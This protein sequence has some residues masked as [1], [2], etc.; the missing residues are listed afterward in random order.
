MDQKQDIRLYSYWRSSASWRIR[1]ALNLKKQSFKIE[2]INLLQGQQLSKEYSD[3]NPN[4]L[5]PALKVNDQILVQSPAI[6]EY[7]EEVYPDFKLLPTDP[8]ERA[9]VRGLMNVIVCDIHPVQN[10]RVLKKV[11]SLVNSDSVKQEWASHFIQLGFK[12]LEEMLKKTAGKYCY[13]DQITFADVCLVPQVYNAQ[14]FGVSMDEFPVI[15]RVCKELGD[16]EEF[17]QAHPS[18]QP[19]AIVS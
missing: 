2:P 15:S 19:D 16:L 7:L 3:I 11:S 13:K 6:L 4:N 5:L 17:K 12:G 10:L 18:M 1:I 9:I 8:F 14:R